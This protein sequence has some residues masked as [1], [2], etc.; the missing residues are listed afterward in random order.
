M[1]E[2]YITVFFGADELN[3]SGLIQK[4]KERF[5]LSDKEVEIMQAKFNTQQ[6]NALC[7]ISGEAI[8]FIH[9]KYGCSAFTY[10]RF[11]SDI[12]LEELEREAKKIAQKGGI[13][14]MTER[15][16]ITKKF[17][18]LVTLAEE[19]FGLSDKETAI[20]VK[21]FSEEQIREFCSLTEKGE[22]YIKTKL[23]VSPFAYFRF[24]PDATAEEVNKFAEKTI[25]IK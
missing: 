6:L 17:S 1:G 14:K 2:R 13:E 3:K 23:Q 20:I 12:D 11:K 5:Q 21:E 7:Q 15:A 25:Q 8:E 24:N 16:F 19:K 4:A 22:M 10:I 9:N 18:E